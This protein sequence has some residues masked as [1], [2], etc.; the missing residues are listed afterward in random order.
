MSLMELAQ[1][2]KDSGLASGYMRGRESGTNLA[3]TAA[4]TAQTQAQTQ[5]Y[6]G[7]T[8]SFLRKSQADA[9]HSELANVQ[10]EADMSA[11]VPAAKA[12]QSMQ[13]AQLKAKQA[14]QALAQMPSQEKLRMMDQMGQEVE[15]FNQLGLQLLQFSGSTREAIQRMSEA[16]PDITKDQQ[17]EVEKYAKDTAIDFAVKNIGE[18][19]VTLRGNIPLL[20]GDGLLSFPGYEDKIRKDSIAVKFAGGEGRLLV[21]ITKY[22]TPCR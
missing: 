13:E 17:F 19:D 11:G 16:Y 12:G 10:G 2:N 5:R 14:E 20:V 8:P 1:L 4:N 9:R 21:L 6:T 18:T 22:V 3:Q 7:E 15:K